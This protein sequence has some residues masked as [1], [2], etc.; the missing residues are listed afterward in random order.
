MPFPCHHTHFL[1]AQD[2]HPES[3][4]RMQAVRRGVERVERDSSPALS[5]SIYQLH[6]DRQAT[7]AELQLVHPAS[8][9]RR[10]AELCS[11]AQVIGMT[12]LNVGCAMSAACMPSFMCVMYAHKHACSFVCVCVC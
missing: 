10:L 8:Y 11:T 6:S 5:R 1:P 7:D 12:I 4:P 3:V 9:L 2:G